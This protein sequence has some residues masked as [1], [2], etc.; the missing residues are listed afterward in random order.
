MVSNKVILQKIARL[1]LPIVL[2]N[3][4]NMLSG[5]FSMNMMGRLGKEEL[6]SGAL[7]YS[8]FGF[9]YAI[10]F[11]FLIPISIFIAKEYGS[12]NTQNI[13]LIVKNG[14]MIA[15]LLGINLF[16]ICFYS[17]PLLKMLGQPYYVLQ[18]AAQY[19]RV[20]ALGMLPFMWLLVLN[21][22]LIGIARPKIML[23]AT[24]LTTPINLVLAYGLI[25]GK[26][27]IP[28]YGVAGVA[29]AN[30]ISIVLNLLLLMLYCYFK[31]DIRNCL[32]G[33]WHA[34]PLEYTKKLVQIGWPIAI[35]RGAEI[36]GL[37]M[38]TILIGRLPNPLHAL[39]AQQISLQYTMVIVIISFSLMQSI[40]VL[41]AQSV[42]SQRYQEAHK[43]GIVA[44]GIGVICMLIIALIFLQAPRLLV[45]FYI[46]VNDPNNHSIL[47]LASILLVISG[48]TQIFDAIRN[49]A[50]GALRGLQDTKIP[51]LINVLGCWLI[52]IPLAYLLGFYLQLGVI[53]VVSG[54]A[55]GIVVCSI[56]IMFRLNHLFRSY[57]R[58]ENTVS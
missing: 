41:V 4:I 58:V 37:L 34:K 51:M 22:F 39:S 17:T 2:L 21:Q 18:Y 42:G 47:S 7:I 13:R 56:V 11:S 50:A 29:Y 5:F 20:M 33:V 45:S 44:I 38:L 30:V 53:G 46:N 24:L 31:E 16:L 36:L 10:T 12:H 35:Q 8:L 40:S 48:F 43:F 28:F 57:Q 14:F 23:F 25:Y 1:T 6:A 15:T 19:F 52:G 49:I 3:L 26:W 55:I 27:G 32:S 9:I 54:F